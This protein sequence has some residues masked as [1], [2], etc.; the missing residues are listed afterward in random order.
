[1][2]FTN[3]ELK[4]LNLNFPYF[5]TILNRKYLHEQRNLQLILRRNAC[6]FMQ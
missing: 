3:F 2:F 4:R 6:V 5:K 1:M